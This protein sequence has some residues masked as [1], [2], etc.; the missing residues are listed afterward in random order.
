[1]E[2]AGAGSRRRCSA[3][4]RARRCWCCAGPATMAATAMSRRAALAARRARRARR[5]AGEPASD[6]AARAARPAGRARSSR[7]PTAEPAPVLVDALFGTGLSRPLDVAHRRTAAVVSP[8]PRASSIAVDLPSGVATDDGGARSARFRRFD[9]TLA[10]GALKPAHLLQPAAR[11]CGAVRLIDIGIRC[12]SD[13][14]CRS[15]SHRCR[16]AA[17]M[18][19]NIR[20][21]WSRWSPGRCPA[22]RCSPRSR[23]CAAARAMSLLL[24]G[25]HG[26]RRMRWS[27][28]RSTTKRWRIRPDRRAC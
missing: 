18:R 2:R 25:A 11:Y 8:R 3:S 20:A 10:L 14:Q 15:T 27:A 19:T 16:T 6:A 5:R 9:M 13:A 1:M 4:R 12:D 21:A 26:G 23:R 24:G 28:S 22:R 7:W 17:P